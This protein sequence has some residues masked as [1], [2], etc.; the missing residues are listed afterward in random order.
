MTESSSVKVLFVDDEE[1]ILKA[2]ERLMLDEQFETLTAA[3]ANDALELLQHTAGVGLIVSDQRMPGVTGVEFLEQARV[4]A[5]DAL[6][7]MLTGYADIQA[8]M[9][10]INRGGAYRYITKPWNDEELLQTI[11][12]GITHYRLLL[13]NRQLTE[14][15]NRQNEE[16]KEWNSRLKERVLEHTARIRLQNEELAARGEMLQGAFRGTIQAF[17]KLVEFGGRRHNHS[18]NVAEISVNICRELGISAEETDKI[19]IAALLHDIGE[20][21][22]SET[23]LEKGI[24]EM[25]PE[26]LQ[27]YLQH[28]VRGQAAIDAVEELREVG[29]LIRHHH[30]QFNGK[31]YPDGLAG[32]AIP[33]GSRIIA[34]ADYVDLEMG[35]D[36]GEKALEALF[37]KIALHA[38]VSLD[39]ALVRPVKHFARYRY[40]APNVKQHGGIEELKPNQLLE[41]MRVVRD[42]YSGTGILLV[43]YN[44][45]LD[46]QMVNSIRRYYEIDPPNKGI[47]VDTGGVA[48]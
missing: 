2:L 42:L 14:T 20:I 41:G 25:N 40:F 13:E 18:R 29:V 1:N 34:M 48:R 47:F 37:T 16:L 36:S 43:S 7:I 17:A 23:I 8:T 39:P 22:I 26:E 15:V 28:A 27:T 46:R 11:R 4:I 3:S 5:P 21:G 19:R 10:A 33:L 44:T 38:G 32:E 30:E 24:Q 9:G 12:D 6:R 31:G 35:D 45:V